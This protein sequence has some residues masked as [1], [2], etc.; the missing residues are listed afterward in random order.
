MLGKN[1][2][3]ATPRS[4]SRTV[5]RPPAPSRRPCKPSCTSRSAGSRPNWTG[6]KKKLP[7]SVE[8]KRAWVDPADEVLSVSR[9][10]ELL[11][12]QRSSYYYEPAPAS[13]ENLALMALIDRESTDHP[14]LGSR[15]L[16]AW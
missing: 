16:T 7:T 10:C 4:Y 2:S 8:G 3:S 13:A 15:G 9:Q 12:L 6:S 5:P 14:F 11:D 1:N